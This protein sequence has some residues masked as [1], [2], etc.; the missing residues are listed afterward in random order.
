MPKEDNKILKYNRG[1]KSSKNPF[2]IISDLEF[3]LPKASSC[4]NNPEKSYA[5]KKARHEPSGYSCITCCSFDASKNERSYYRRKDCMESF[6]KHLKNQAT[7]IIKYEKKEMIA[8]TDD[9][10]K[11]L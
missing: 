10:K 2:I 5:E 4:Q 8:L 6:S 11:V 3:I 1:E 7:K 9:E